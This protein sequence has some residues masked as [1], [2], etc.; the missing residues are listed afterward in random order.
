MRDKILKHQ[1]QL[2]TCQKELKF[3]G[4]LFSGCIFHYYI[5]LICY[6]TPGIQQFFKT[7]LSWIS[8]IHPRWNSRFGYTLYWVQ[9]TR[10]GWDVVLLLTGTIEMYKC[11]YYWQLSAQCG[12]WRIQ[13][14]YNTSLHAPQCSSVTRPLVVTTLPLLF[15]LRCGTF[16]SKI[17]SSY[18][19]EALLNA[20]QIGILT[21]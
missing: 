21:S 1:H 6:S 9:Q 10:P 12:G 19:Q 3:Q 13:Y 4:F 18:S 15:T 5:L 17:K 14:V 2:E 20:S 11:I 7:T 8:N 16:R